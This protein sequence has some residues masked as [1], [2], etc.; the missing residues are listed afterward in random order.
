MGL[1]SERVSKAQGVSTV[2]FSS[3]ILNGSGLKAYRDYREKLAA[4][5]APLPAKGNN[6]S[7]LST[8][9]SNNANS[10]ELG[11]ASALASI[12]TTKLSAIEQGLI[13]EVGQALVTKATTT[14]TWRQVL[15]SQAASTAG[16]LI[17]PLLGGSL[18]ASAAPVET[19]HVE[20]T[21]EA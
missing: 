12:D 5:A 14:E 13:N 1:I 21:S 7:Q 4:P 3:P 15:S 20:G 2:T 11:I 17:T 8:F 16:A 18:A 19:A 6:M 9:I 10:L